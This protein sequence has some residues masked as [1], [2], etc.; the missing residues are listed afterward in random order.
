MVLINNQNSTGA[1]SLKSSSLMQAV[2][3][4]LVGGVAFLIDAGGYY[5]LTRFCHLYYF[6]ARLIS[7]SLSLIWNFILNRY[8]TFNAK[9]GAISKQ[10]IRF[11]IVIILTSLL[12]V[13]LMRLF[14]GTFHFPD[15]MVLV[16]VSVVIAIVNF[17]FH[18]FWSYKV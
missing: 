10:L 16:F 8:W 15:I 1:I 11:S 4:I 12:N 13:L 6:N 18:R 3:F 5:L 7:L 14:V 17:I 9:S 2:R